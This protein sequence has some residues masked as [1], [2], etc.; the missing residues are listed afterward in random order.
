MLFGNDSGES[1]VQQLTKNS[2]SEIIY[3]LKTKDSGYKN[4]T[5]QM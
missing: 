4:F 2:S 1:N 3:E 5:Y